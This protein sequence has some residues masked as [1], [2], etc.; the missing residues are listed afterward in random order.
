VVGSIIA[1]TCEMRLA[2]K[3][4]QIDRLIAGLRSTAT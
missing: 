4:P 2:G 3:P 1:R